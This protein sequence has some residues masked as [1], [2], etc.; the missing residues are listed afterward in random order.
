M[1]TYT[2]W[3]FNEKMEAAVDD[4]GDGS[5]LMWIGPRRYD[6]V[7]LYLHGEPSTFFVS[8]IR[9]DYEKAGDS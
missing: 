2:R 9:T 1:E 6:R 7:I 4:L 5:S 8:F 3:M